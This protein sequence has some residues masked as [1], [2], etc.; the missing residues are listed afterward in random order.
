M[1][2]RLVQDSENK[3][4]YRKIIREYLTII[5]QGVNQPNGISLI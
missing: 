3:A 1:I 5:V 4:T 2:V